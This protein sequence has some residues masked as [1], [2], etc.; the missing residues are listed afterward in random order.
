M[1][2]STLKLSQIPPKH[3][4][5]PIFH[6]HWQERPTFYPPTLLFAHLFQIKLMCEIT[7]SILPKT[8]AKPRQTLDAADHLTGNWTL[9]ELKD[10]IADFLFRRWRSAASGIAS[11]SGIRC[12]FISP[13]VLVVAKSHGIFY[14]RCRSFE[15]THPRCVSQISGWLR[16]RPCS[17]QATSTRTKSRDTAQ[18]KK[19]KKK[20]KSAKTAL[21][22]VDYSES[23]SKKATRKSKKRKGKTRFLRTSL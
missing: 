11:A 17:R 20:K 22:S 19:K 5:V 6:P 4:H 7:F 23:T 9:C 12:V 14:R 10:R 3:V 18:K 13:V 15:P 2:Y 21:K 1:L 8:F 16:L